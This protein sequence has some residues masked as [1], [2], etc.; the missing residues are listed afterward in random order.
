MK[1]ASTIIDADS[2]LMG[3]DDVKSLVESRMWDTSAQIREN[4]V[5]MIGKYSVLN[6]QHLVLYQDVL[7]KR[8]MD[9]A[10]SVRKRAIKVLHDFCVAQPEHDMCGTVCKC[11]IKRINDEET[12][13]K[14]VYEVFQVIS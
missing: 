4:V 8:L 11:I 10:P 3:R 6:P 2:S 9:T 14:L 5:E 1:A 13:K 12:I 7:L